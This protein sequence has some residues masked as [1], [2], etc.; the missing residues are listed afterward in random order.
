MHKQTTLVVGVSGVL[1]ALSFSSPINAATYYLKH[2]SSGDYAE[3][4]SSNDRIEMTASNTGSAQV[5]E[6]VSSAGGYAFKAVGGS[7]DG[8]YSLEPSGGSRQEMTASSLSNAEV[9]I[10]IDCGDGGVYFTSQTTSANLKVE[11]NLG[12]G[13]GSGGT[14]SS[15]A[16]KFYWEQASSGGTTS[17]PGIVQAEDYNNAYDTSGGNTGGEYRTDDVDIETTDDSGGGYNVGWIKSGE[18]LEYDIN[19]TSSGTYSLDTRVASSKSTG[20]F[21]V[22]V[23]GTEVGSINVGNTGGWQSWTTKDIS[24]GTLSAGTHTVRIEVTGDDFNF[25][26]MEFSSSGGGSVNVPTIIQAEDYNSF[27]DNTAGNTG[28]Q[29][30]SDDVDIETNDDSGGGYNVGWIKSGEWLEYDINVSSSGTY[31]V[32]A[33]VASSKSTGSFAVEVDGTEVGTVNVGN[34]GGWQS[35]TTKSVSLGNLSAGSHTIR[36]AV[37]GND[38]NL[39]WLEVTSGGSNLDPNDPPSDNFDL[40]TWN[41][42]IPVDR[43]DGKAT[44][45]SVA[46]L[47]NSYESDLDN[48]SEDDDY[49][50][51]TTDG[52]MVFRCTNA[53]AKTSTNTSYTRVELREMLRGTDTSIDTK[54]VNENNWVFDST[55]IDEQ[56]A[57]GGVNGNMTATLKVDHVTTTGDSGQIGRVI[58]GQI[59]AP[60]NEPVRLYYRKLPGNSKGSIYFAHEPAAGYGNE[61]W[62]EMIG[63]KDSNA[64]N[65]S[66]G[67]ELGEVFSY[68]IDV[69]NDMLTV[70]IRRDGKAD[71]VEDVDMSGSGYHQDGM[72]QYFKAGVYNQNNTGDDDDFVQATFYSLNKSHD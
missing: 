61:Q 25:N 14:C 26:W 1:A 39:N 31:S 40:S 53:G 12:L 5:F 42:S 60:S 56:L 72:Y 17:V 59:H 63:S 10:E 43:G 23:D 70:T 18:W 38:F 16:N 35:W 20:A 67:I 41:L 33:R 30:R 6:K 47:N 32:A 21:T 13:N 49:F 57:A 37:T 62:I 50:Y 8:K 27:Y 64:S 58:I 68:E 22:K 28:G 52:G 54:G 46:D 11:S 19:V 65:P 71:V 36:I 48:S 3:I 66:D 9:F 34:T 15:S 44:T 51:T 2:V 55:D 7:Y 69:Q 24:L 4:N 45:I 29:Y